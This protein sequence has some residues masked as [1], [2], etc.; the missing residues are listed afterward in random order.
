MQRKK[1]GVFTVV[2]SSIKMLACVEVYKKLVYLYCAQCTPCKAKK[3]LAKY[4]R[5]IAFA[6][7]TMICIHWYTSNHTLTLLFIVET[8]SLLSLFQN[9]NGGLRPSV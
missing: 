8:L 1:G 4:L 6:E 7:E 5:C 3:L 2:G 9:T